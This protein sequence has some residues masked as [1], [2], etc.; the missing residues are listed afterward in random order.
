MDLNC[1]I[2]HMRDSSFPH[3]LSGIFLRALTPLQSLVFSA[4]PLSLSVSG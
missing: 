1:Q 2:A 3:T 4:I